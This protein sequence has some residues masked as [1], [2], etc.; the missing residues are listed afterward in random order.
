MSLVV[1][2]TLLRGTTCKLGGFISDISNKKR[3]N[4]SSFFTMADSV[5]NNLGLSSLNSFLSTLKIML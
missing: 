4:I 5:E 1:V 2:V 3:I